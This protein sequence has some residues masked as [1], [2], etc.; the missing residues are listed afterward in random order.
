MTCGRRMSMCMASARLPVA[1]FGSSSQRSQASTLCAAAGVLH[2]PHGAA[3]A[4]DVTPGAVGEALLRRWLGVGEDVDLPT[5][6][7]QH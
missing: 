5:V 7:V 6:Q 4:F 1:S 3:S 2:A